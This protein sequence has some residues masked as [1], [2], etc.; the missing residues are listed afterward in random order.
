MQ[1]P[2]QTG[3]IASFARPR[4]GGYG[5][6][7]CTSLALLLVSC[8]TLP[9]SHR[10]NPYQD[11]ATP[12]PRYSMVF[13][14]HGDG[15][16]L[17][18]DA[19]G[20]AHRADQ[21]A[22]HGALRAAE[23]NE[24]AEVFV[25]HQKPRRRTLLL[26]PRRG[27]KFYYYRYGR[28]IAT[29]TYRRDPAQPRFYPEV[30]LYRRYRAEDTSQPTR[31][32]LYYGHAI[33]EYGGAG[34]DASCREWPFTVHDFASGL[35]RITG[36]ST[37]ND[38]IVLSTCNSGTPYT[39]AALAPYARTIVASPGDLHLSYLDQRPLERLEEGLEDRDIPAF[40]NDY[41]RQAFD[42]LAGDVQTVVTVTVY[43]MERIRA[44]VN[45]VEGVYQQTLNAA[46]RHGPSAFE[47]RDCAEDSAYAMPGMNDGVTVFFRPPRFGR[48][49][50]KTSHSGWECWTR[51]R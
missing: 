50:N 28:L 4:P 29:E 49:K 21:E 48:A 30:A 2:R 43:D 20:A 18:H 47:H 33:P 26:F 19:H 6:A 38:L 40:A 31:L 36:D 25:Y 5:W 41:A 39:I 17:Y 24:F 13:I 35:G 14:I 51:I 12:P 46:T 23:R 37:K 45:S 15:N 9:P 1:H 44:Y 3:L 8:G 10:E 32:L 11:E 16:Y 34:Y 7:G 42:R 27:G 22:L